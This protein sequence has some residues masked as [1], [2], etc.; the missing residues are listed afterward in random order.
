MEDAATLKN[1]LLDKIAYHSFAGDGDGAKQ[2]GIIFLGGYRSNMTGIKAAWLDQWARARG[3]RFVRFDYSGHGISQGR[4]EDLC[5]SDWAADSATVLTQLTEGP[6]ILVGS[7]MG[8]WIA[9]LLAK[10]YPERIAGLIGIAAAPDFTQ[11]RWAEFTPE[12]RQIVQQDG[13]IGLPSAYS[14]DPYIYTRRLFEDGRNNLVLQEPLDLPFPVRLLHGTADDAVPVD[15]ALALLDH[16]TC[17]DMRLTLI[18][19]ADHRLSDDTALGLLGQAL[20]DI[21]ATRAGGP[22][23]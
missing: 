20:D 19:D 13:Q 14:D 15:V 3:R 6:Q 17:P 2:P 9:L 1:T 22:D 18:K 21:T 11:R 5:I 7:S 23:G 8:G 4:F 10:R 12:Q 16:A